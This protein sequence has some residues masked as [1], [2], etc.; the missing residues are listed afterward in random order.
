MNETDT[1]INAL[2]T[3]PDG[4][5]LRAVVGA[6]ALYKEEYQYLRL[7]IEGFEALKKARLSH[8]SVN[9]NNFVPIWFNKMYD[10]ARI[11]SQIDEVK[12]QMKATA[13]RIENLQEGYDAYMNELEEVGA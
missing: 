1:P 2:Q 9:P 8:M 12:E 4:T 7:A 5:N 11:Q 10:G 6:L 13:K 3:H